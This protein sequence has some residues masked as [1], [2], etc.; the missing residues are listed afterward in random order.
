MEITGV[1]LAGTAVMLH[2]A[3]DGEVAER[4]TK[5]KGTISDVT[6]KLVWAVLAEATEEQELFAAIVILTADLTEIQGLAVNQVLLVIREI[7]E[8]VGLMVIAVMEEDQ[9]IQVMQD[10]QDQQEIEEPTLVLI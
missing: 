6:E 7:T 10:Q 2:M 9:E 5:A 3:E 4:H 8:L 1:V